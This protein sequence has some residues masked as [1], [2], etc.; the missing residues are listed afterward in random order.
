MGAALGGPI[1]ASLA[2][3]IMIYA[4][5]H[6][7]GAHYNPAVSLA[8][9]IRGLS[10]IGDMIGYWM[11]QLAGAIAAAVVVA[12]LFEVKNVGNCIVPDDALIKAVLLKY[13]EHLLLHTWY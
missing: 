6:I 8:V 5:G 1:G 13:L 9:W 2:L 10:K 7:S 3:M 12:N 11:A 4:G